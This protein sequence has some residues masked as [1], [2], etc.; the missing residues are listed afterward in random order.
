[1]GRV[2]R[3][4]NRRRGVETVEALVTLPLILAVVFGGMEFGWLMM[5]STQLN[6]AA[7]AGAREAALSGSTASSVDQ[8]VSASLAAVGIKDYAIQIHPGEPDAIDPGVPVTVVVSADYGE[9][10]LTG[11]GRL[12]PLPSQLKG[13][14][15]MLKEEP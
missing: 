8:I 11:F 15:A 14:S 13:S 4:L 5:R 9:V 7:Q 2:R 3:I 12:L 6:A 10:G 1:M